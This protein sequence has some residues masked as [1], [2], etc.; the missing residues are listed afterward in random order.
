[1]SSVRGGS[2]LSAFS[3]R[4]REWTVSDS[5][6]KTDQVSVLKEQERTH[7]DHPLPSVESEAV[8]FPD[9]TQNQVYR[10]IK[11]IHTP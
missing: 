4:G 6:D 11:K 9:I 8:L 10:G 2:F 7:Q 1:M 5:S 3:T